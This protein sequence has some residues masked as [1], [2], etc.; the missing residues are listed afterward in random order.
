LLKQLSIPGPAERPLYVCLQIAI[1]VLRS[2]EHDKNYC[3][4]KKKRDVD[5]CSCEG[6]EVIIT[7]SQIATFNQSWPG[8]SL[9]FNP[10]LAIDF[11][12]LA[13]QQVMVDENYAGTPQH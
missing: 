3:W 4:L 8:L 13:C 7:L 2:K 6:R 5:D 10:I 12:M 9:F 1:T 11:Q